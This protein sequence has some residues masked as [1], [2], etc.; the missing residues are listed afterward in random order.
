MGLKE[1]K[2][3]IKNI[4]IADPNTIKKKFDFTLEMKRIIINKRIR[5][6]ANSIS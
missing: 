4:K 6:S 1:N 2:C 3:K 5:E